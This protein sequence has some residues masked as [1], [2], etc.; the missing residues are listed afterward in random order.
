MKIFQDKK[1]LLFGLGS[2]GGGVAT[3]K[4]L[5]KNGAKLRITD[6]KNKSELKKSLDRLKNIK[7][8][9]I[10]GKHR[11]QDID[12]A[13]YVIVNPGVSYQNKFIQYALAKNKF[14]ENDCSLFFS[15]ARGEIIAL[16]GTRGKTTTTTWLFQLLQKLIG[17]KRNI[18]LGGNQPEKGLL[19]IIKKA[20]QN[21][22]SVLE[23]SSFQLEFYRQGL[24]SPKIAIITSIFNDHLNRYKSIQ[25]YLKIKAKIFQNQTKD[26]YLILNYDN[27]WTKSI[28]KLNPQSQ[29]Y[30]VSLQNKLKKNSGIYYWRN[31]IFIKDGNK[32]SDLGRFN[33]FEIV[34]G[35]HNL[36]N[37]LFV[38][39]ACYLLFKSENKK[40]PKIPKKYLFS[41]K[42]PSYR[43]EIVYQTKKLLVV[44]DSAST[45]PEAVIVALKR[46]LVQSKNL[47]LITGG[48]DKNLNFKELAIFLKKNLKP[49][50]LILLE[51]TATAKLIRHLK[52]IKFNLRQ[53]NIF[54]DLRECFLK[55][56]A[57]AQK[58]PY[59]IIIFS[60]GSASFEKFKNEF[61]RGRKFTA[62]VKKFLVYK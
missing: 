7:A 27:Q 24:R 15:Q 9:Y 43:Q 59:S 12:W 45:S 39:L 1:V 3:A 32:L 31:H 21:S 11:Y 28:L 48:T 47:I 6:L 58:F 13:D 23:L 29:V 57:I 61:D 22:L 14:V 10:L 35:S 56:L 34:F 50:N 19:K 62:L 42:T 33:D 52:K 53:E 2:L 16:T 51:G 4:W 20:N 54:N 37:L 49:T 17:S 36:N 41:F 55:S 60:P 8:T 25:E 38:F 44:N 30:F 26:D 46:F 18:V 5:F 40:L